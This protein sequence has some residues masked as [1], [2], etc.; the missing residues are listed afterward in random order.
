MARRRKVINPRT[1]R[2]IF[3]GGSTYNKLK[4]EGVLGRRRKRS[5]SPRRRRK[6]RPASRRRKKKRSPSPRR[7]KKRP[8]AVPQ[9][10]D[11]EDI[12]DREDIRDREDRK[13]QR[14]KEDRRQ[15]FRE[16]IRGME[17]YKSKGIGCI[18]QSRL[19]KYSSRK[20]PPFP[21]N[22]CCGEIMRGNDGDEYESLPNV[23]GICRWVALI[24]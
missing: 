12:Q 4:R 7:K 19:K 5:A 23:R 17:G 10:E 8:V 13:R 16:S 3:V 9:I 24:N 15:K 20:S 22:E 18:D 11:L 1:G 2:K 21:A 6:K 14:D